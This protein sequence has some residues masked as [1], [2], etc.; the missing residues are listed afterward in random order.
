MRAAASAS[1]LLAA[2]LSGCSDALEQ[3]TA[4]GQVVVAVNTVSRTL[5][6]VSVDDRSVVTTPIAPPG[7]TARTAAVL[8]LSL[9]AVPAVDSGAIAVYDFTMERVPDLSYRPL[10]AGSGA[11]GIAITKDSVAWVANTALNSVSRIDFRTNA[12]TTYPGEAYPQAVVVVQGRVFVTNTSLS[13]GV[14][15]GPAWIRVRSQETGALASPDSIPLTGSNARYAVAG[16][17]GLVYVVEAGTPGR[18][19]GKV[20]IVDP[21]SLAE[22]V[23][24]NGLGESPGPAVYHPTGRLLVASQTEGILEIDTSRR[25]LLRGAGQG[26][27]P[28][29]AGI[30]A[31][32]LDETGR[33]YAFDQGN[34]TGPGTLHVLSPPPE[35]HDDQQIPVGICPAAAATTL[36]P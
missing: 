34:C 21:A 10:P 31:L 19:D 25:K 15:S 11:G 6:L 2:A 7:A 36:V 35:Y 22:L 33:V 8:D 20:S 18:G 13:A 26:L 28:G 16:E 3:S 17:D 5:S 4:A 24:M 30:A 9:L 32:A 23:V 14:P 1:L 29:G 12:V 27:K